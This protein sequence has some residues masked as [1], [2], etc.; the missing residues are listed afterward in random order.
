M[1]KPLFA[2]AAGLLI[3]ASTASAQVTS[4]VTS[5]SVNAN[6]PGS[7]TAY[8]GPVASSATQLQTIGEGGPGYNNYQ[9]STA[10]TPTDIVF[11]DNATT[12]GSLSH[13]STATSVN[14]T[15]TNGGS[16]PIVPT[17]QSEIIPGGFGIYVADPGLNPTFAGGLVGDV[18]QSPQSAATSVCGCSVNPVINTFAGGPG[19][20]MVP[21]WENAIAG[22]SFSFT[23][24]SNG[25]VV[26]D[27][28]GA[29]TIDYNPADASHPIINVTLSPQA[30]TALPTF[31]LIT[32]A[33]DPSALGYQWDAADLTVPLGGPLAPG[34]SDVVSYDTQVTVYS[35]AGESVTYQDG[36]GNYY[37]Y[38]QLL[39]YSGFGDPIGKGTGGGSSAVPGGMFAADAPASGAIQDVYFP[40]FQIGLPTFDPTTGLLSLPVSDTLLPALPLTHAPAIVPEPETWALMLAGMGGVAFALRRR[41]RGRL[42]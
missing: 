13:L 17:L 2:T 42:A 39:A 23:V 15:F 9:V 26:E 24:T 30:V 4:V 41:G 28:S 40:R 11:A 18:N 27:I 19:N 1:N 16:A 22:A 35:L 3:M 33:G 36:H 20:Y 32:P 6:L 21:G 37:I 34:E 10:V 14:I 29:L 12:Q 8:P 31:R 5:Q 38:P 7:P 25:V